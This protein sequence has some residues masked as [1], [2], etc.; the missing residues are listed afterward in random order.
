[1]SRAAEPIKHIEDLAT[2]LPDV[3]AL[4]RKAEA[5]GYA[6]GYAACER[7]HAKSSEFRRLQGLNE[8]LVRF[9]R[10]PFSV[11]NDPRT[12]WFTLIAGAVR[13]EGNTFWS[14]LDRA[15]E[16]EITDRERL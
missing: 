6:R 16:G 10:K 5:K 13:Y 4:I 3:D 2:G 9:M 7:N 8:L 11:E 12:G 14:A 15:V 1:M